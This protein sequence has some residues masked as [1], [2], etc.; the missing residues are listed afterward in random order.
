M[1]G[2]IRYLAYGSNM[3]LRR[4]QARVPEA[5][6]VGRAV[7]PGHVLRFHKRGRDGSGKCDAHFTGGSGHLV[8]VLF[9]LPLAGKN[10][11]DRIEG[12]GAGYEQKQVS[13]TL[14]DGTRSDALT[15][16]A[17]DIDDRLEPFCWY[18]HHVMAGAL[19]FELPGDYIAAID[20]IRVVT[21]PDR[22]RRQKEYATYD[23]PEMNRVKTLP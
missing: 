10:V 7:L 20:A 13:V 19:E 4:L 8:G 17:T 6:P 16:Y 3:S 5:S 21:D 18:R 1:N 2:L 22:D 9:D 14:S 11:L 23:S 15:Y 12:L